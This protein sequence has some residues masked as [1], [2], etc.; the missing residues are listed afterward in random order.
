MQKSCQLYCSLLHKVV[1]KQYMVG[2][3]NLHI[4]KYFELTNYSSA[5][6]SVHCTLPELSFSLVHILYLRLRKFMSLQIIKQK[7]S[8]LHIFNKQVTKHFINAAHSVQCSC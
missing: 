5:S 3:Q 2:H 6:S 7:L 4:H 8:K 1:K